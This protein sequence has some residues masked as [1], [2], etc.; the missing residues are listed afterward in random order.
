MP[1]QEQRLMFLERQPG[2]GQAEPLREVGPREAVSLSDLKRQPVLTP[3]P[4]ATAPRTGCSGLFFRNR[5][6]DAG[7]ARAAN[8][9]AN[10]YQRDN[11]PVSH[12]GMQPGPGLAEEAAGLQQQEAPQRAAPL[13]RK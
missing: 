11:G 5:T 1:G 6:R 12:M 3:T 2:T 13:P 7:I 8:C 9:Q 10:Q 4:A